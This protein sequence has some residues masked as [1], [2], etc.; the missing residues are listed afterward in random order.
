[1]AAQYAPD[2]WWAAVGS[3]RT[4]PVTCGLRS[5]GLYKSERRKSGR[6]ETHSHEIG[7]ALRIFEP[8]LESINVSFQPSSSGD[9]KIHFRI[10]ANLKIEPAPE[11]ITFDT[12]VQLG[13][14]QYVVK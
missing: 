9:S 1:M 13:S 11:P 12:T 7:E 10:D 4:Q 2:R 8:R 3:G 5:A 6:P 14:G